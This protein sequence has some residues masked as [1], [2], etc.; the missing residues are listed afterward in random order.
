MF[1]QVYLLNG[2]KKPL[3]Y[4][5]P[6]TL[7]HL[8]FTGVCVT[9][10]VKKTVHLATVNLIVKDQPALAY[11][12]RQIQYVEPCMVQ[13]SY[14]TF[15]ATLASL[16]CI[17]PSL[18]LKRF[19]YFL[20]SS[21]DKEDLLE[22]N[23]HEYTSQAKHIVELTDEQ[24]AVCNAILPAIN[25][26]HYMASLLHGV[27]GSGKT[28]VYKV[29]MMHAVSLGKSVLF[30]LPEVTLALAFYDRLIKECG[31]NIPLA[32]FHSAT[33][34]KERDLVWHMIKNGLPIIIVGVH[35]PIMLPFTNLGLII[36]DEEHDVGYQEKKHP[37]INSKEAAIL[38]AQV[39]SIPIVL[40]S[41]T[42]SISTL[43]KVKEEGW[44]F[45]QLKKRF[46]G[47]F[48]KVTLVL[49]KTAPR[50]GHFWI[51]EHLYHA[52]AV[53][54]EKKQQVILFINRRGHSFFIQCKN[55]SHIPV[56]KY[57]SVSLTYHEDETVRCHYCNYQ[58]TTPT[59]CSNCLA[60]DLLKKGLGTQ[61]LA[62]IL[63]K[64]FPMARIGRI[65]HD[66]TK[67]RNEWRTV[68][69]DF[70]AG[71]LDILVGTQTITKGY[72]FKN[73]GLV[74]IIWADIAINFPIY[75]AAEVALQQ[76]IQVAGRAGRA[77]IESTVIVQT[78]NDHRIFSY[79]NEEDYLGFY[80]S[81]IYARN[82]M[83]YP[84]IMALAQ[85]EI[86]NDTEAAAQQ[87]ALWLL[88]HINRAQRDTHN[89]DLIILGPGKPAVH[90]IAGIHT[91]TLY[92]KS[93]QIEKIIPLIQ[94]INHPL[95][96]G[97]ALLFTPNPLQ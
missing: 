13:P 48:P 89:K 65:D 95:P 1:V 57:C 71:K 46:Y 64:I 51:S 94:S 10:P 79:V 66:V 15:I 47:T 38:K 36:V 53:C 29:L 23:F 30:L 25:N 56:C 34:K 86:R 77:H 4:E 97:S 32:S 61:Q 85:I 52:I 42:P 83:A 39:D 19:S 20:L 90:T 37:K 62:T 76:I 8:I 26:P 80:R 33:T 9:V 70:S 92:I 12:L 59:H 11:Q 27:T 96:A 68:M 58:I 22:N 14:R 67:K 88:D 82:I 24:R 16:Y 74:G 49:M 69:E 50:R 78:M 45:F 84:P 18:L 41:A 35:L 73:V 81:E 2:F 17:S 3:W 21:E 93:S 55:C 28:E 91:R 54:L 31:N 5:V 87:D 7:T 63:K 6:A 40:G 44:H 72:D 43:Y 75:N 60:T